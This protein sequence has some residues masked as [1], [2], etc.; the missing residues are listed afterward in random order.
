MAQS[1]GALWLG[2]V[3]SAA[4]CGGTLDAGRDV[5]SGLLPVDERN[6]V[7]F[8]NDGEGD[9]WGGEYA[10]LLTNS[11]GPPLVGLIVGASKYWGDLNSNTT[12]WSAFLLAAR[13]SGLKNLPD[14]TSSPSN[15]LTAPANGPIESTKANGSAGAQLIV[16][17]SRQLS[18]PV[19]PLV[20]A[21]GSRL[22]DVAD[23]YLID[24]TV[25]DRVVVVSALGAYE[26]PNG[27]MAGPNGELDPWADWIVAQRFRYVQVSSYYDQRGDITTDNIA[28][29]PKNP[30]GS[31]MATKQPDILQIASASDQVAILAVGLPGF[32]VAVQRSAADVGVAFDGTQGPRLIP[33]VTG[34]VWVVTQVAGPLAPSRLWQ[35]LLEPQTFGM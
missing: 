34:N 28:S 24:P 4:A 9:N 33:D 18:T 2:A 13:R 15:P 16:D 29:L 6:P 10:A 27:L 23:A 19:R 17:L 31:R 11:G 8:Y 5:P 25:I 21:T 12:N 1:P 26:A 7:I 20:V 30:L 32:G 3:L 22:T 35:M 14:V